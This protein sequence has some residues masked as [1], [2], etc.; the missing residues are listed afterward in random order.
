M[1][2]SA[3]LLKHLSRLR[4]N[5]RRRLSLLLICMA[6]ILRHR[7]YIVVCHIETLHRRRLRIEVQQTHQHRYTATHRQ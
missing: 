5:Q 4:S 6:P 7:W 1:D 3:S 2:C